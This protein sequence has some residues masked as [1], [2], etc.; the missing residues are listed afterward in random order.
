MRIRVLGIGLCLAALLAA[1]QPAAADDHLLNLLIPPTTMPAGRAGPADGSPPA[2]QPGESVIKVAAILPLTGAQAP[3]GQSALRGL[4]LAVARENDDSTGGQVRIHLVL[5]DSQSRPAGAGDLAR[6][7]IIVERA[8]LLIGGLDGATA[9]A[10]RPIAQQHRVLFLVL[11]GGYQASPLQDGFICRTG[12]S[13]LQLSDGL[14]RHAREHLAAERLFVVAD[15]SSERA[16]LTADIFSNSIGRLGGQIVGTASWPAQR[17][18]AKAADFAAQ[19]AAVKPDAIFV[20]LPPQPLLAFA[21]HLRE[22]QVNAPLLLIPPIWDTPALLAAQAEALRPAQLAMPLAVDDPDPRL[23]DWLRRFAARFAQQQADSIAAT[24]YD[25]L[26]LARH[27]A[28]YRRQTGANL[29]QGLSA[30]AD[31]PG[32]MGPMS[33]ADGGVAR[34]IVIC[35]LDPGEPPEGGPRLRFVRRVEP[36]R[37]EPLPQETMPG[38][39]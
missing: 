5:L 9:L 15:L 1:P 19:A 26:A 20:A 32:A 29:H 12:T 13:L 22:A 34:P 2:S 17:E 11:D 27:L 36:Q 3:F 39:Q 10:I 14:A 38:P 23:N 8:D 6:R 35:R 33:M 16:V 21:R 37:V 31:L 18:P 28:G 7:A 4:E 24:A 30:I 25:S